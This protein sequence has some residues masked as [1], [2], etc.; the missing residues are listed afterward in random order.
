MHLPEELTTHIAGYISAELHA[1]DPNSYR[2]A[3]SLQAT[4]RGYYVRTAPLSY[5]CGSCLCGTFAASFATCDSCG[6]HFFDGA[7]IDM[8]AIHLF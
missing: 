7:D 4:W 2:A 8:F 1:V 3:R 5:L 6:D